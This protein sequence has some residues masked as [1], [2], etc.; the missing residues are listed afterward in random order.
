MKK[1]RDIIKRKQFFINSDGH[2]VPHEPITFKRKIA[3]FFINSDGYAV[4]HE[5]VTFKSSK[6]DI[7]EDVLVEK[8]AEH[9]R[10]GWI[11]TDDNHHLHDDTINH[12]GVLGANL[13]EK[14]I[15]EL[16]N[17]VSASILNKQRKISMKDTKTIKRYTD[18]SEAIN[19]HLIR[20]HINSEYKNPVKGIYSKIKNTDEAL[21]KNKLSHHLH[22]YTGI[23]FHPGDMLKHTKDNIIHLPAYTSTTHNKYVAANFAD[24]KK[25]DIASAGHEGK[26]LIHLHLKP[27]D[28]ATHVSHISYFKNEH[29]TILPRNTKLKINPK[30]EIHKD[31][32]GE[33]VHVWHATIHQQD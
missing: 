4:P 25:W 21:R 16:S 26:H 31:H 32:Y 11:N 18:G 23:G 27:G 12:F 30:P 24:K 6:K 2:A 1:L 17:K 3:N 29:E 13:S 7:K 19:K 28:K 9:R 22:V 15:A 14:R 8:R 20:S 5:P 33:D 10:I